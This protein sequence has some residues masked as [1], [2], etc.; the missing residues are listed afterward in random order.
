VSF[1]MH[2]TALGL[3]IIFVGPD[4]R[5][6]NIAA[7]AKPYD[8]TPLPSSGPARAVLEVKAGL[9]KR[10]GIKVGDRVTDG[11]IFPK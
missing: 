7:N 2:N 9:T 8:E 4:G 10:F 5:V 1:W 6:T 11:W 3:D